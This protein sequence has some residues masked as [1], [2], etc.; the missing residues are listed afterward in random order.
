[1]VTPINNTR[2]AGSFS[3]ISN[4]LERGAL[5]IKKSGAEALEKLRESFFNVG[6]ACSNFKTKIF[7]YFKYKLAR[8]VTSEVANPVIHKVSQSIDNHSTAVVNSAALGSGLSAIAVSSTAAALGGGVGAVLS[9]AAIGSVF[10]AAVG[11]GLYTHNQLP[12]GESPFKKG[13]K[14]TIVIDELQKSTAN[15][16]K[17]VFSG[18]F[19]AAAGA[20]AITC[21]APLVASICIAAGALYGA[22]KVTGYI[23]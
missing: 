16:A 7:N 6:K 2:Q 8:T 4:A 3:T 20:T 9:G 22:G 21:G 15:V 1:M 23:S 19:G 5:K 14:E 10:G 11:M 12:P 18:I 17:G 13:I